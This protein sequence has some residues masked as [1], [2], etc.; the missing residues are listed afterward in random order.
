MASAE[1]P[2]SRKTA[3]S[4]GKI[5]IRVTKRGLRLGTGLIL[6]AFV[7]SHL[8][9]HALGLISLEALQAGHRVFQAVWQN[10]VANWIVLAS[11]LTHMCLA[12]LAVYERRRLKMRI[13]EAAQ[14][15]LGFAAPALLVSHILGTRIAE[16]LFGTTGGYPY[17]LMALWVDDPL[18]GLQQSAA[19]LVV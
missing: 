2:V 11:I 9:N 15:L 14:L 16:E 6:F 5:D 8:L 1:Q 18:H 19:T 7:F 13:G 17:V 12:L 10:P 4:G 3:Q